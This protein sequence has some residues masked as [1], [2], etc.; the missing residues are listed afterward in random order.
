MCGREGGRWSGEDKDE[1]VGRENERAAV[2]LMLVEKNEK[3]TKKR[4]IPDFLFPCRDL[5][6]PGTGNDHETRD[7]N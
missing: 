1:G 4:E 2:N 3:R 7:G 6:F 5:D